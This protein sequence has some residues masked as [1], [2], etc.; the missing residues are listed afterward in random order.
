MNYLQNQCELLLSANSFIQSYNVTHLNKHSIPA[1]QMYQLKGFRSL[2][3][4][5]SLVL[6]E[7]PEDNALYQ[8]KGSHIK[9]AICQMRSI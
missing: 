3:V 5:F 1:L 9:N 7:L 4:H 6:K 8:K 2:F